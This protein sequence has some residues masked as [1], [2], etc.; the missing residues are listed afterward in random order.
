MNTLNVVIGE[1]EKQYEVLPVRM[2]YIRDNF[3]GKY[4][5][6]KENGLIKMYNFTDGAGLVLAFLTAV[7]NSEEI[8][9]ELVDGDD[10]TFTMMNEIISITQRI[11]ELQDEDD[12][13]NE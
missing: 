10:L 8:A 11:N 13:K 6:I 4:S 1:S 12:T 7:F 2:K 9:Q 5:L 3:Y